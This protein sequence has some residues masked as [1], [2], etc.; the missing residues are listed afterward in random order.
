MDGGVLLVV[1]GWVFVSA[2]FF[3]FS[4]CVFLWRVVSVGCGGWRWWIAGCVDG[5]WLR[6][7][8]CVLFW[9][10]VFAE[11]CECVLC[12]WWIIRCFVSQVHD[13]EEQLSNHVPLGSRGDANTQ[14]LQKD[15]KCE[16]FH[17]TDLLFCLTSVFF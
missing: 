12:W 2:C 11:G 15:N 4:E 3:F 17:N 5:G 16:M 6:V 14:P 7:C 10:C 1:G 8:L 9:V 13:A